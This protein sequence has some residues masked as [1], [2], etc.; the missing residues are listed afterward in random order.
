MLQFVS[1]QVGD[2]PDIF[3][4][5][6][7]RG[8]AKNGGADAPQPATSAPPAAAL[9]PAL[10]ATT[11][12]CLTPPQTPVQVVAPKLPPVRPPPLLHPRPQS[13]LHL[14]PQQ[15]HKVALQTQ[16]V[17]AHSPGF[18]VQTQPVPLQSHAQAQTVMFAPSLTTASQPQF[19]QSSVV[20]HQSPT[21]GFQGG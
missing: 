19:I 6:C 1:N 14:Q 21:P 20:Y 7:L 15:I 4:D 12:Q 5:Q 16:A 3:E 8:S 18:A 9:P 13:I 17:P 10:T 11:V 2:F